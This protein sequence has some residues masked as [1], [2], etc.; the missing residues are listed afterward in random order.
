MLVFVQACSQ[1][2]ID[3]EG[4][5]GAYLVRIAFNS[6]VSQLRRLQ[7]RPAPEH[8]LEGADDLASAMYDAVDDWSFL[9]GL[10]ERLGVAGDTTAQKVLAA[11][12]NQP[13]AHDVSVRALEES[14]GLSRGSVHRALKRIRLSARDFLGRD[15]P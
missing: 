15:G 14:T 8:V 2:K 10:M 12:A 7:E 11:L 5:P 13:G 4:N 3:P 6:G 9:T 1:G